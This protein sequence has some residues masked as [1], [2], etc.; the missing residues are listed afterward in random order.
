MTTRLLAEEPDFFEGKEM[1]RVS[2]EAHLMNNFCLPTAKQHAVVFRETH[3]QIKE[4]EHTTDSIRRLVNGGD[5]FH[6]YM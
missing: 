1:D 6:P 3:A 4:D 2:W 5:R